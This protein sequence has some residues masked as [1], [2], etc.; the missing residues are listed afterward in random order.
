MLSGAERMHRAISAV[1]TLSLS[2]VLRNELHAPSVSLHLEIARDRMASC[3]DFYEVIGRVSRFPEG[4]PATKS[5][6]MYAGWQ[7]Q[8]LVVNSAQRKA[9]LHKQLW[10]A[11]QCNQHSRIPTLHGRWWQRDGLY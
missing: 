4:L 11:S 6:W 2:P 1:C 7:M 3:T 9:L 10:A 8:Q 5:S